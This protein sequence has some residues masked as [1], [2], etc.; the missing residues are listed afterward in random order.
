VKVKGN[1]AIYYTQS[2][3]QVIEFRIPMLDLF[4][5]PRFI[6][7]HCAAHANACRTY[8]LLAASREI[9]SVLAGYSRTKRQVFSGQ[10]K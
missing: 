2:I 7:D 3:L 5:S 10:T 4:L 9:S 1:F 8:L 6:H